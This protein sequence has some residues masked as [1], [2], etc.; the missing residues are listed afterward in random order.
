MTLDERIQNITKN[1]SAILFAR[2]SGKIS[3]EKLH[4]LIQ[5]AK[6][7][8]LPGGLDPKGVQRELVTIRKALRKKINCAKV[9]EFEAIARYAI[10]KLKALK[11]K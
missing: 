1:R 2:G 3:K 10:D 7:S 4:D 9:R 11:Q 5:R 6:D 8:L